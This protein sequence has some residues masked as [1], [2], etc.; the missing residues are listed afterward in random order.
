MLDIVSTTWTRL[1]SFYNSAIEV[2]KS[3]KHFYA[4]KNPS[5]KHFT[6]A[7]MNNIYLNIADGNI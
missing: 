6:R 7:N 4:V 2:L 3:S 1:N 5:T